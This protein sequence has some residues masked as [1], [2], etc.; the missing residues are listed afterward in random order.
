L[1]TYEASADFKTLYREFGST[2][3]AVVAKAT[4]SLAAASGVGAD[5]ACV[6]N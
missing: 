6:A 5:A 3:D 2:A 1:T 4:Q